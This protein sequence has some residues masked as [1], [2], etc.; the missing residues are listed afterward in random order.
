MGLATVCVLIATAWFVEAVA[1][2]AD[3]DTRRSAAAAEGKEVT[4]TGRLVDLHCAIT[5]KYISA[6]REECTQDCLRAG[7]TPAL[8]TDRGL[9]ILGKGMTSPART[10]AEHA[11]QEIRVTGKLYEKSGIHY[12]DMTAAVPTD[13]RM[14]HETDDDYDYG[15]DDDSDE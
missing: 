15:H 9:V 5:G 3:S 11:F 14:S 4:L 12:L 2:P 10:L 6:D 13:E 1:Q 8:E 7:V